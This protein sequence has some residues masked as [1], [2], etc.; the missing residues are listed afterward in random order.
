MAVIH[1]VNRADALA[2]CLRVRAAVEPVVLIEDAVYAAVN[3]IPP[4]V[5]AQVRDVVARGLTSRV[6]QDVQCLTD[7]E[8]VGLIVEHHPAV[9]WTR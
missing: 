5:F 2:D 8:F 4:P 9:T 3:S 6:N 1:I 7:D